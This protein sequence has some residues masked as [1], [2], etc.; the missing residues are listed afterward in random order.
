MANFTVCTENDVQYLDIRKAMGSGLRTLEEI[1]TATNVC[2]ICEGCGEHLDWILSTVCRC[3]GI[4][5]AAV[6]EAVKNGADTVEKV[7]EMTKAGTAPDC[8]RCKILIENIVAI[9]K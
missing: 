3:L 8:G 5:M 4:S 1:K 6:V 7:G 2:G 9:G